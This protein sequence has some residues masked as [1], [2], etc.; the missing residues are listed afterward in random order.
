MVQ[1]SRL[2]SPAVLGPAVGTSF[3]G[4]HAY[5][6]EAVKLLTVSVRAV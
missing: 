2:H 5:R 3:A 4:R 6:T 1:A